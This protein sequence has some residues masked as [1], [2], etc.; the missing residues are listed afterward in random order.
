[1]S[2]EKSVSNEEIN[3]K[4]E[5]GGRKILSKEEYERRARERAKKEREHEKKE[6]KQKKDPPVQRDL[7]R[8]RDEKIALDTNLNKTQVVQS[9]S[10][11]SKQPGFY[12]KVCDC[13]VKDSVN[14]LDHINGRKHQSNMGMSM[15]VE[16]STLDEVKARLEM[17]KRKKEQPEKEYDFDERVAMSQKEEEEER[18]RKREKKKQKKPRKKMMT[19]SQLLKMMKW[20]V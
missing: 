18:R 2:A 19:I 20:R 17:L 7:L 16:R 8:A 1:M 14:Y 4:D 15:R 5:S 6:E 3:T 12:C 9:T 10:I 13:V 11:A